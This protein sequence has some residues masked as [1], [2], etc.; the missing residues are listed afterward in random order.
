[1]PTDPRKRQK[2]LERRNARRKEKRHVQVRE[3]SAGLASQLSAASRFPV[4]HC[5][6]SKTLDDEGLGWVLL[7]R[8]T[9]SGDVA[10]VV[11]LVDRYCLGVKDTHG[12]VLG[13]FSYDQKYTQK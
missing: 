1:M 13:R 3:A 2:K 8:Q 9:P 12:E 7:S 4:L 11:F 6:I 5:W 10:V